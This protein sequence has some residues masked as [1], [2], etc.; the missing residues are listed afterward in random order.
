MSDSLVTL[1]TV[2]H[3]APLSMRF[4]RQEYW[5]GLPCPLQGI[6]LTQRWNLHLMHWQMDSLSAELPRKPMNS[7]NNIRIIKASVHWGLTRHHE[8]LYWL[9][10][11]QYS[12]F[13]YR[14]RN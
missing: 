9:V 8:V 5:S 6:F 13:F 2:A 14:G 11:L 4:P 10:V 12:Y 3:H 7:C 1:W